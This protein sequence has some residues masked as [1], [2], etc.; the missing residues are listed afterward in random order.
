MSASAN[1]EMGD[2]VRQVQE[3]VRDGLLQPSSGENLTRWLTEPQYGEFRDR[4]FQL[5]DA[6]QYEELDAAFWEVIDFG[7]GGRRGRMGE[8]GSATINQRTIAES[9]HGLASYWK[10]ESGRSDGRAVVTCDTR[11]NSLEFAQITAATLAAHGLHVFYFESHR[12]TP[13]LSFAVRHLNCDVGV[14]VSASHNPPSDN[15]FKAYW[16]NGGQVLSPHDKG[17]IKAVFEAKEIP[18]I[19]FDK[20]VSS[21][22]IE[23]VGKEVDEAYLRE[24][25]ALS[26]SDARD[27]PAVYSPLHGVGETSVYPVLQRLGFDRIEILESQ[28]KPDGRFPNVDDHKPNPERSEVY[29]PAITRARET[30]AELILASDPDADRIGI[31]VKTSDGD[32]VHLSGNRVGALIA[33][34]ILKKR[35]ARGELTP[36]HYVVETMV[37]TPL[38][39]RIARAY[40][41]DLVDDLLV[42]FKFIGQTMDERGADR[43]VFGTEESLGY[44]AGSYARDKDAAVAAMYVAELAA[45]LRQSGKTL[46]DRLDELHVEHGY[47]V[48]GQRSVVCE[49]PAGRQ[50]I[51]GLMK[52]FRET[53]PQSLGSLTVTRVRDYGQLELRELP[54]NAKL[55][56]I[57][58]PQGNL[59]F[60]ESSS[61][62]A[63]ASF[64]IRPSGTE[65]KIKFYLFL[66]VPVP[67]AEQL[68]SVRQTADA[69]LVKIGDDLMDWVNSQ[70]A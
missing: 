11:I 65:P 50:Q 44:L 17:I 49:G 55:E 14:M 36:E 32:F 29:D 31:V 39:G 4:L 19:E 42:G 2:Y 13:E 69:L 60:F 3:A 22:K 21:G 64:A 24:V 30:G 56:T 5:I 18:S 70:I 40:G 35:Q 1:R 16:S 63:H 8:L 38:V 53:P 61:D 59:L 54:A 12:S 25:T 9:A 26:L 52:A 10:Q 7:T 28:R 15:G 37:T 6:K 34:Y 66:E 57:E 33:D 45:E 23:I 67:S 27:I 43:F 48:E 68:G 62:D 58:R 20:A 51:D 41:V 47:F 46:I